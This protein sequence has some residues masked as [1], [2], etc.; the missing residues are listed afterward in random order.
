[1]LKAAAPG[2][3]SKI[4]VQQGQIVPAGA[5]L[6]ELASGNR[7]EVSLSVEPEDVRYLRRGQPVQLRLVSGSSKDP[8]IG[9]IRVIS[10]RVDPATRMAPVVVSLPPRTQWMLGAYVIGEW[11]KARA[12]GLV[13]PRDAVLSEQTGKYSLFTVRN[14]HAVEHPVRLGLQNDHETQVFAQ[15]LHPG[16]PIVVVGNHELEDGMAVTSSPPATEPAG[17]KPTAEAVP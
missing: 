8:V 16:E 12:R 6:I 4:D 9:H 1:M 15:D 2:I 11:A 7:I 3:V 5:P 10:Q 13:V 17:A 14:G